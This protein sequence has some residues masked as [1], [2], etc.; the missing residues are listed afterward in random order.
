MKIDRFFSVVDCHTGGSNVRLVVGGG[1][2]ISGKTMAEKRDYFKENMDHVRQMLTHEPRG[3]RGVFVAYLVPP[4]TDKADVGLLFMSSGEEATPSLYPDAVGHAS[5]GATTALIELGMVAAKEPITEVNIDTAAGLLLARAEF[6]D[7][8][9][10]SVTLSFANVPSFF[11]G[12]RR[13]KVPGLGNIQVDVAF[14]G[15]FMIFV[16]AE[17]IGVKLDKKNI[18]ELVAKGILLLG[19]AQEQIELHH[20]DPDI[21]RVFND[22]IIYGPPTNP[23]AHEKTIDIY[24]SGS[25]DR[26][27]SGTVTCCRMATLYAKGKLKLNEEFIP[28]SIVGSL[29]RG[30]LIKE[31]KVGEYAA[32]VPEVTGSAYIC[33]FNNIVCSVNDPFRRGFY[34]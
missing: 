16:S 1:P 22:T 19:A 20:P 32:V 3:H 34:I 15:L 18:N 8:L 17:D 29:F 4:T 27:P 7:G 5:I 9:V 33:G 23:K 30:Q 6:S 13:I 24:G 14:G 12:E 28:E 31:T 2:K 25:F 11:I 21:T 10:H 26:C